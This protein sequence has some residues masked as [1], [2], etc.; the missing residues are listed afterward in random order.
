MSYRADKLVIYARTDTHIQMQATPIP[1]DQNWLRVAKR[2]KIIRVNRLT[3]VCTKWRNHWASIFSVISWEPVY[4]WMSKRKN[5]LTDGINPV[6]P[7]HPWR[8]GDI[9]THPLFSVCLQH[10]CCECGWGGGPGWSN[11]WSQYLEHHRAKYCIIHTK[12]NHPL[13]HI[14][15]VGGQK[16]NQSRPVSRPVLIF[17]IRVYT[18]WQIN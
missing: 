17:C 1:E 13:P 11:H 8:S 15:T 14:L 12:I 7:V 2:T 16:I 10:L 5:R 9:T 18:G 4:R 6:Y 3:S